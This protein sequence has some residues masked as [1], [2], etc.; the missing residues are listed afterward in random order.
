MVKS[1]AP[2]RVKVHIEPKHPKRSTLTPE[3]AEKILKS[4]E[5][6]A[7]IDAMAAVVRRLSQKRS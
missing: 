2:P 6:Q 3:Q 7:F 5:G 1:P 4:P